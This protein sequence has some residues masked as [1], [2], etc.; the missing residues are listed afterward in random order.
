M[1]KT[2]MLMMGAALVCAMASTGCQDEYAVKTPVYKT[3]QPTDTLSAA[4]FEK[5][6]PLQY[7]KS[8]LRLM[9]ISYLCDTL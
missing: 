4:P 1:N 3:G 2:T 8:S 6:F 9:E 5:V 7:A